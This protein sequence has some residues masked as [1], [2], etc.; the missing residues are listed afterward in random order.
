MDRAL[1]CGSLA[2]RRLSTADPGFEAA[3]AALLEAPREGTARVDAAVS[4][5]IAA[6]RAG[7]DRAVLDLTARFDGH[8]PESAAALR[9]T[10]AEIDEAAASVAPDL[11][12][13]P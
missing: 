12:A 10:A 1:P 2:L 13:A 5:I 8:A 3:F 9:V 6:V 4:G 11:L 7:G